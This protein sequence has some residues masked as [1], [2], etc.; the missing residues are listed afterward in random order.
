LTQL[1]KMIATCPEEIKPLLTKELQ[2][3]GASDITPLYRAVEFSVNETGFY[4]AHLKLRTPS[5]LLLVIKSFSAKDQVMLQSQAKRIKW[6]DIFSSDRTYLVDGVQTD[7]GAEL[8]TSNDVSKTVRLAIEDV[9][10][11]N[12]LPL[13]KVDLKDPDIKFV[14]HS[15]KGRCTLS[16]NTT[17]KSLHKRGYRVEGHPAP[18]K[19][20][21]AASLL[22]FAGYTGDEPLFDAMCGSGTLAIEATQISLKKAP[23]IHRK[24]GEFGFE[25][26]K[27]FNRNLWR[28]IQDEVRLEKSDVPAQPIS[29][30]DISEGYVEMAK[31]NA[32]RARVE[33]YIDFSVGDFLTSTPPTEKGLLVCNLPYGERLKI[34]GLSL[35]EFYQEVGNKLKKDYTGWRVAFMTS[36]TAPHKLIGLKTTRRL[37]VLNGSIKCKFLTYDMYEGSKKQKKKDDK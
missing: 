30:R 26:L 32:L 4:K 20:T 13:P 28:E 11:H 27:L 22:M 3:L 14:A 16:I 35:E 34:G 6:L 21:L 12:N 7:R 1:Y 18:M 8:M 31:S 36:E 33:K 15:Q 23:M 2:D 17:G 9:F 5:Q 29:A 25:S 37:T 24:K 10:N 19:E